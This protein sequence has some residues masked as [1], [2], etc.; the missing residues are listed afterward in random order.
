MALQL[1]FAILLQLGLMLLLACS[2]GRDPAQRVMAALSL[3]WLFN[4]DTSQTRVGRTF[5]HMQ[6]V[7]CNL[8]CHG[9]LETFF[10]IVRLEKI[11]KKDF[12]A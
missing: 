5:S 2:L 8:S 11:K 7:P 6:E 9:F 10:R 3:A 1:T 4:G 12:S